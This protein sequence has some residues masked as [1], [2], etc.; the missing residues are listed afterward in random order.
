MILCT[1]YTGVIGRAIERFL[2]PEVEIVGLSSSNENTAV[3]CC[4]IRDLAALRKIVL[5]Y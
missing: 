1:G 5:H 4:D 3:E 2:S